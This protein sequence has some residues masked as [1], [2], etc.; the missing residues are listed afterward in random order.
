M[1]KPNIQLLRFADLKEAQV[2]TNWPQVG[3]LI[4]KQG[5]PSGFLLS[6]GCRV[7]DA[8]EVEALLRGRREAS[9][10]PRSRTA[11]AQVSA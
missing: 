4:E 7:W 2:V 6:P 1:D 3:R 10:R 11:L 5:F 9:G 8:S